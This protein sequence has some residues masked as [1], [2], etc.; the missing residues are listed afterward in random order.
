ML[1]PD[2]AEHQAQIDRMPSVY[3]APTP[4][5]LRVNWTYTPRPQTPVANP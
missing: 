1:P 5:I 4:S 2:P 3:N